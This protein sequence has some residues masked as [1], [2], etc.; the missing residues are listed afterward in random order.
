MGWRKAQTRDI[1]QRRSS[2][3]AKEIGGGTSSYL[4][5]NIVVISLKE[6]KEGVGWGSKKDLK[7]ME[8]EIKNKGRKDPWRLE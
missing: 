6:D 3:W 7:G 2:H 8:R 4:N 1:C 5:L